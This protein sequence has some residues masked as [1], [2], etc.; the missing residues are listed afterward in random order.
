MHHEH[1]LYTRFHT[2]DWD[3]YPVTELCGISLYADDTLLFAKVSCCWQPSP[4]RWCVSWSLCVYFQIVS[5]RKLTKALLKQG[6]TAGKSSITVSTH[7][8]THHADSASCLSHRLIIIVL[9][10]PYFPL[11]FSHLFSSF[12]SPFFPSAANPSTPITSN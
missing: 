3:L 4:V 2:A 12:P 9:M 1:G 10:W 5:Q 6:N 11:R 8:H 7:A